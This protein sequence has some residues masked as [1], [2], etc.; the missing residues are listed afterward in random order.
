MHYNDVIM[1]AIT[2]HIT[3]L[4][5]VYSTV[6]SGAD[7]RKN[8]HPASLAF[9]WGIH[10]GLVNSLRKRPVT[11]K[12]L[13]LM[14]SSWRDHVMA[15]EIAAQMDRGWFPLILTPTYIIYDGLV[16]DCS[17]SISNA[18]ELLQSCTKPLILVGVTLLY[19]VNNNPMFV[20][21]DAWDNYQ[22]LKIC[23]VMKLKILAFEY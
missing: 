12:C 10:R 17:N 18:L 20:R 21:I 6:Y 15:R 1:G 7:Q 3:S 16:Q 2:S 11:R 8:Q 19:R 22:C 23:P 14:M 4:N 9:A 13:H 5:I